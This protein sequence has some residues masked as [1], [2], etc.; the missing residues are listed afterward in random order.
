[1][2]ATIKKYGLY[3][4]LTGLV[5]FILHLTLG[6]DLSYST[7]EIIGYISIFISLSFVFFGIKHYRDKVNNGAV[8]FGKALSIGILISV[9]VA[10]G[11]ALADFVYTKFINP[12]WFENYYQMMRDAGKEDEIMEMTS[13]TAGLFMLTL[14][15]VIGFIISLISSL[16]LQRK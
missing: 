4:L 5:I 15:T 10:I 2:Q 11:I 9:L 6:K 16:V 12:D 1:M 7:N 14:V 8:S 13:F 3:G